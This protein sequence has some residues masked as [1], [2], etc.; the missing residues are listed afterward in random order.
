MLKSCFRFSSFY[1]S[2]PF[3]AFTFWLLAFPMSGP[4]QIADRISHPLLFFLVPHILAFLSFAFLFPA[5]HF[6]RVTFLGVVLAVVS[7][8][9][10]RFFPS[11]SALALVGAGLG[12]AALAVRSG[13]LL[14]QAGKPVEAAGWSLIVANLLL[15]GVTSLPLGYAGKL[16]LTVIIALFPLTVK[17][18]PQSRGDIRPLWKYLPFVLLYHVVAG[19][20][21]GFLLPVYQEKAWLSG[22][23]LIVYCLAVAMAAALFQKRQAEVLFVGFVCALITCWFLYVPATPG[24]NL[25]MWTVQA[26]CGFVDLFLVAFLATRS[27]PGQSFALGC[28]VLCLG[29]LGGV[30]FC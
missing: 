25:G 20:L 23:E 10:Y 4:L 12:G 7:T 1:E 28:A 18:S 27:N 17:L 16:L 15:I 8:L 9:A 5:K 11:L 22:S 3:A 30:F 26:A 29:I 24:V 21:Y 6:S 2:L 13:A 14:G 19:L